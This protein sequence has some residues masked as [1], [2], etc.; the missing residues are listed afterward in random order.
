MVAQVVFEMMLVFG[1]EGTMRA[2]EQ[3]LGLD[4]AALMHPELFFARAHEHAL[5]AF[6]HFNS[7]FDVGDF[8]VAIAAVERTIFNICFIYYTVMTLGLWFCIFRMCGLFYLEL[9]LF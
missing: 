2:F 9:F 1:D 5:L 7:V 8:V 4:V 6:M 3:L